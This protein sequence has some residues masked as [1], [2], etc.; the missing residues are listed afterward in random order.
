MPVSKPR[1]LLVLLAALLALA[2]LAVAA[3]A[4]KPSKKAFAPKTG[5]YA[6][7]YTN[8]GGTGEMGAL[9]E[10]K[11]G[12][13]Y[14]TL[15]GDLEATC[16]DGSGRPMSLSGDAPLKGKSFRFA[17]HSPNPE[18]AGS[19]LIYVTLVG[20]FKTPTTFTGTVRA[21]TKVESGVLE[22]R[23]CKVPATEISLK[24]E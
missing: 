12:H 8:P 11:K 20:K 24:V 10:G 14:V 23:S 3:S 2:A 17:G 18:A 4:A 21:E 22:S 9:V 6:G 13:Y 19:K 5:E 16:A 7:D 15:L 1:S